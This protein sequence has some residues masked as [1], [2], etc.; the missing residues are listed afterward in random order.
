MRVL[1][2]NDDGIDAPG[3]ATLQ[4]A[5]APHARE[6][7]TVA[8]QTQMSE[9][10]HRFTVY[11]PIPVEQRT[12][13]AYAVAGTPADCT[14]LGLTQFAADVDWVLSGVNAG[15]NLGVDIYTS[16]T[17]AAVREATILGKRAIAFSHFI[18]RP[19]EIDWDLVTHWTGKLLAQLLTQELQ[20]KHFWNV[21]FPHLTADSDP[22][23][24]FCERSTDP[25]QVRYEARDQQ[26]H[27]VGSYPE[28]PRAAGTDVD[29][30]FSGNIAV[31]QISI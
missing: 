4:K 1:L 15:G 18:Q 3:I 17:V 26:F 24:I 19:L 11:A 28:R 27:Y 10:G 14:R 22:E 7:V 5:I 2:T 13:N 20:E 31:T 21:N 6:V 30:C 16:G 12:K 9:C 25:M 29:V 8:P 23:I